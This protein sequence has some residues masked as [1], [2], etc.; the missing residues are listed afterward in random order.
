[1]ADFGAG[2]AAVGLF[3]HCLHAYRAIATAIEFGSDAIMWDVQMRIERFRFEIWARMLGFVDPKTGA[4]RGPGDE[5]ASAAPGFGEV[6]QIEGVQE[7]VTKTLTAIRGELGKF[8]K[9]VKRYH[10]RPGQEPSHEPLKKKLPQKTKD[11]TMHLALAV[12]DPNA[13]KDLLQNLGALNDG[14]EKLLSVAQRHHANEALTSAVLSRYDEPTALA[15]VWKPG[16]TV[17]TEGVGPE[18]GTTTQVPSRP[19]ELISSAIIKQ[20]IVEPRIDTVW[21]PSFGGQGDTATRELPS[22]RVTVHGEIETTRKDHFWPLSM[23]TYS[24][25]GGGNRIQAIVEW[26]KPYPVLIGSDIDHGELE[27]RRDLIVDL[28]HK[29]SCLD[30]ASG[31]RVL[32]CLGYVKRRGRLDGE[33]TEVIGFVS[34]VPDWADGTKE[35]VTLHKLLSDA[36]ASDELGIIPSLRLRFSLARILST[37]LYRLQ[38]SHWLHR[39][40]TSK[41]I[42]FFHDRTSQ[43]P[44]LDAPYLVGLQYS[45]PDDQKEGRQYNPKLYS[46]G[47]S[48]IPPLAAL[49]LHPDFSDGKGRRY[50]RSDDVYS[51]GVVLFEVAMWEPVEC[52]LQNGTSVVEALKQV[53]EIVEK[54][55]ASEVGEIYRDAVLAC[56]EGL[57]EKAGGQTTHD[58]SDNVFDPEVGLE[59]DLYWKVVQEIGKCVV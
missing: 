55:L 24:V 4:E 17:S 41:N 42:V 2:T 46:E 59:V 9:A 36:F 13:V 7:I 11:F 45:R 22:S 58:G 33:L 5:D 27:R 18:Q 39:N 1:M 21:R 30:G 15:T 3:T 8:D 56:L 54:E 40:L 43:Q 20:E 12:K 19:A 47:T 52:Y 32:D 37:A 34:A 26:R 6:L 38:C 50:R 49:Y 23:A 14:L 16:T 44:R 25:D 10:L 28:L 48:D 31:Y 35:P 29:T 57:R 53:G 51:L